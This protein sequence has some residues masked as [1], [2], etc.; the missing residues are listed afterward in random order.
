MNFRHDADD[1]TD[2]KN[3]KLL[4]IRINST[5]DILAKI[6]LVSHLKLLF[7]GIKRASNLF[8]NRPNIIETE[9]NREK[10]NIFFILFNLI[11]R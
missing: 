11:A 6:L 3:N 4:E 8:R 10:K 9:S 5:T 2:K 1:V 7:T